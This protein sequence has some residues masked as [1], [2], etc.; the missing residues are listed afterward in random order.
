MSQTSI[1]FKQR[2]HNQSQGEARYKAKK[3]KRKNIDYTAH[4]SYEYTDKEEK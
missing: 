3:A 1:E 2:M 4:A